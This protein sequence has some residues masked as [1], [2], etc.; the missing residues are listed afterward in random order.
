[1]GKL[2]PCG[3]GEQEKQLLRKC[4]EI[5]KRLRVKRGFEPVEVAK[6]AG[7]SRQG[8]ELAESEKGNPEALS[9]LKICRALNVA[10]HAIDAQAEKELGWVQV[11]DL[12][13]W[14]L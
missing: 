5:L 8:V 14:Q 13:H 10:P 9:I 12:R 3:D 11:P 6:A 4:M 7:L 1:L 2:L